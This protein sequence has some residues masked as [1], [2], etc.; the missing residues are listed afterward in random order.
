MIELNKSYEDDISLEEIIQYGYDIVLLK[1]PAFFFYQ[2]I[3]D[4]HVS[5]KKNNK[6]IGV[7]F[8]TNF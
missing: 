7:T 5:L 3:K 1:K 2:W 6:K 8:L 4:N